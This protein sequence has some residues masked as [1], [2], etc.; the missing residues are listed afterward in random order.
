MTI[1]DQNPMARATGLRGTLAFVLAA[2][3]LAFAPASYGAFVAPT[4]AAVTTD[5]DTQSAVIV[6][7][8]GVGDTLTAFYKITSITNGTLDKSDG[9]TAI[10]NNDFITLAEGTTGVK[11][12]PD[13]DLFSPATA[14][15]SFTIEADDNGSGPGLGSPIT[16]TVTVT[17]IADTPS[18]TNVTTNE[19]TQTASGLVI[20]RNANDSTEVTHFKITAITNGALFK[21]DGTT[22]IAGNDFIT[23]AEGNAG[24]KFTPTADSIATGS[25]QFQG[26][27]SGAGAGLSGGAATATIAVT[28]IADTPSVT[29]STTNEDLQTTTGLVI[30]RNANDSTEVTHFKITAITNGA[31]FRNDGTTS[32]SNNAFITFAQANA[33]LKF[34]PSS[35][36][37]A[38]GSFAVQGATSNGG[39]G[40]SALAAT[41]TI[42]VTPIAD[43]PSVTNATTNEDVQTASGLV[44]SR[45][46]NDSTEVTHFKVTAITNGSLFQ[47]DGTTA[48][49]GN[50]FVTFAQGNAG[51]KFTPAADSFAAGSFTIQASTSGVDGGLGGSTAT[52]TITVT[53]IA[54]T[55]SVTD[56]TTNED[57]QSSSGLVISRNANDSTEVTHFKITSI[58]NGSLFRND[59]TT[60]IANNAFITFAQGNAGLKFTP[61]GNLS[62]PGT[63]F[64]FDIQGATSSGGAGLSALAATATITVNPVADTPS[65]TNAATNEDVQTTSGLVIS[66]NANDSTEVTHFKVT[67]ITNGTL[68]QNDGTTSISN[69]AFITFA[70]GNVGLKFTPTPES[71]SNGSFTIQASTSGVDGGLGGS[72]AT[73][74]I[75]VTSI[76]DTPSVTN[77]TTNEDTQSSSGLVI[78]RNAADSTEVT[79]FKITNISNGSLFRNDGTT[80]IANDA[81]ITFSQGNAG[82]KFT[83]AS[84]TNTAGTF[85]IQGATSNVGAGL[86]L[87]AANATITIT[88]INDA[89]VLDNSGSLVLVSINE[90]NFT[91]AGT[92]ISSILAVGTI[93][94]D[95]PLD[96]EGIAVTALVS[97]NG[98][99]EFSLDAGTTWGSFGS[100]TADSAT[101][102]GTD[103]FIR[104]VPDPNFNGTVSSGITF[105]AWDQSL[106]ASGDTA[107]DVSPGGVATPFS[108][109]TETANIT[110][111][112]VNDAPLLNNG[113][114]LVFGGV[115]EDPNPNNGTLVSTMLASSGT[116]PN[117]ITDLLD[118]SPQEG[119]AV[120][121]VDNTNGAWQFSTN[122]GTSWAAFGAP[123]P[124]SNTA[125]T[126]LF[127]SH[128][129]RFAPSL[130]FNGTVATG[131]TFRGWDRTGAFASGDQNVNASATG[132]TNP[133]SSATD[134][135]ALT[136]TPVNDVPVVNDD[137]GIAVSEN[138]FVDID[139]LAN[140]SDVDNV[141]G[142]STFQ[143]TIG[144]AHGS[145]GLDTNT[146]LYRY[147]PEPNYNGPDTFTYQLTDVGSPALSDS[148]L[149]SITVSA[150][151]DPPVAGNDT[152]ETNVDIPVEID[153]LANDE[154][155]ETALDP[156][157]VIVTV[158][159]SNG[160]TSV[161]PTDGVITYTPDSGFQGVDSFEYEVADTDPSS[162]ES[163]TANVTVA[164]SPSAIEVDSKIDE[165]D[166]NVSIPG[167]ISLREAVRFIADGG[168]ITFDAAVFAGSNEITL[169][170]GALEVDGSVTI[171]GPGASRL[172]INGNGLSRVFDIVAGEV[173]MTGLTVKNGSV[174]DE[175]GAGLRVGSSASLE[176]SNIVVSGN[177]ATDTDAAENER[178]GGI[179]A[180]G[181]LTIRDSNIVD[182]A[183]GA[184]GGI[185]SEGG[186][187]LANAT[188]SGNAATDRDG[189]G[190]LFAGASPV[191]A[192]AI[193]HATITGNSAE[194]GG[195]V[196]RESGILL[197]RNSIIAG[198]SATASPDVKGVVESNGTNLVE[199]ATGSEAGWEL[200]DLLGISA[201]IVLDTI[202]RDNGG[203]VFTH[204]LLPDSP[205]I[206][207]GT[208]AAVTAASLTTDQR[209]TGFPRIKGT[210]VDLGAYETGALT[211][212][213]LVDES[214]NPGTGTSLREALS[215]AEPGDTITVVPTGVMNLA[216][217][218]LEVDNSVAI[219]AAG[220]AQF[221]IDGGGAS[222]IL[223][224]PDQ[225]SH[226]AI[227][228]VTF[229][230][231]FEDTTGG[232]ALLN[233]GAM[234]M[235]DC[236][237][238]DNT[239]DGTD[240]GAVNN[241][242]L[243]VFNH[244]AF[245]GNVAGNLGG[246]IIN[247]GGTLTL[248][249]CTVTNN[250]AGFTGGG[251]HNFLAGTVSVFS[252]TV[253]DNESE[254]AAGLFNSTTGTMSLLNCSVLRNSAGLDGGGILNRGALTVANSTLSTNSATRNGGGIFQS[255]GSTKLLGATMTQNIADDA[256]SGL[257][258]GGGFKNSGGT[259]T[260]GNSIIAGNFD[261]VNNAAGGNV[262]P[263]V[264]GTFVT[265]GTNL[266]GNRNGS[267]GFTVAA[268]GDIVGTA[269]GPIVPALGPLDNY[270]GL[271]ETHVPEPQSPAI[272][273]GNDA[274]LVTP[275]LDNPPYDQRGAGF[276][277]LVDGDGNGD[278]DTV[279]M[280]ALEFLTTAPVFTSAPGLVVNED[281]VY[282]YNIVVDDVDDL[283]SAEIF[284]IS[285]IDLPDWLSFD[286]GGDGTAIL[287]GTPTN[288]DVNPGDE[289]NPPSFN[290]GTLEVSLVVEDWAH[291]T[292]TQTFSVTVTGV[293]DPPDTTDD[294]ENT[295]EDTEVPV[296]VL[297][298]DADEDGSEVF[299]LNNNNVLVHV[300]GPLVKASVAVT[301]PPLHGTTRVESE[302]GVIYY[303]PE[304]DFE[305]PSDTFVYSVSDNGVP[306]P[307]E[308]SFATVVVDV[309][310]VNDA[311]RLADDTYA[312]DED[313]PLENIDVLANDDD[314][315]ID[316]DVDPALLLIIVAPQHGTAVLETIEVD[317]LPVKTG[318]ITYTP[319]ADYNGPDSF[320]YRAF[321]NGAPLPPASATAM[322]NLTIVS[323]NDEP[324]LLADEATTLEDTLV[325]VPVLANDV[326]VDGSLVPASLFVS[327][328]PAHG[329]AVVV[330]GTINYTPNADYN[331]PD[332]LS[333]TVSDNGAPLPALSSTAILQISVTAVN[334][335]PR[336]TDDTETTIEDTPVALAVLLNDDDVDV[337]GILNTGTL[338]VEFDLASLTVVTPPAHGSTSVD[339]D[340]GIVTYTPAA[341]FD[342][343][344]FFEYEITDHGIPAPGLTTRARADIGITAVNDTPRLFDDLAFTDEEAT[345][346]VAVL[347]HGNVDDYDVDGVIL[348]ANVTIVGGPSNGVAS[349][350]PA[351]AVITYTPNAEFNGDDL[352]EYQVVDES[353]PEL[354]P[355]ATLTIRVG[356]VNDTLVA[357]D[358]T[359]VIDEDEADAGTLTVDILANDEDIDGDA[360]PSSVTIV[361][362]ATHGA[363]AIDAQTGAITYTPG[364]NFNGV[365]TFV[366]EVADFGL[367]LPPTTS[368]ATVT[369]TV[370]AVN[371][372][373]S[374]TAPMTGLVLQDTD[375]AI[376]GVAI[377][378]VDVD[379]AATPHL[380]VGLSVSDGRLTVSLG[381]SPTVVVGDGAIGTP[382]MTLRGPLQ[383]LNAALSTLVY[384]GDLLHYQFDTVVLG[385]DDLGNT[386]SGG[387][388]TAAAAV[389]VTILPTR[390]EVSTL[391]DEDDGD[392]SPGDV[393]LREAIREIQPG[394]RIVFAPGLT[395]TL[396]MVSSLGQFAIGKS[397]TIDG[398]GASV[399]T[400][401]AG[402]ASR[403]FNITDNDS[404][405][406]KQVVVRGLS[407]TDGLPAAGLG[408]GAINNTERLVIDRCVVFGNQAENGGGVFTRGAL[409]VVDTSGSGNTAIDSGG[410]LLSF[411]SETSIVRR[412]TLAGNN[413]KQGGAIMNVGSLQVENST[414][415]GNSATQDGGAIYHGT[416]ASFLAVNATITDNI[417][418]ANAASSGL[419]GGIFVVTGASPANLRNSIVA[420]N[421][422]TPNN[423]GEG[424]V[425]PDV[426]GAFAGNH[427]NIVGLPDGA[428]GFSG[429]DI[430]FGE[431]GLSAI[432]ELVDPILSDNG[433]F[434]LTHEL[435]D[436]G[437]GVNAGDNEYIATPLEGPPFHDQRGVGFDRISFGTVDIGAIE[438]Q[439]L[440]NPNDT[441][442]A[443]DDPAETAE[444]TPALIA[445]LDNDTDTD[446][447]IIPSSVVIVTPAA[448]GTAV[449]NPATGAVT[450]TPDLD[451]NGVDTFVYEVSDFGLP[452]PPVTSSATVTVT[453]AA[454]N[455]A[456]V[457]ASPAGVQGLQDQ[458][459]PIEG[460]VVSDVDVA[461]S[462][463]PQIETGLTALHGTLAI[464]TDASPGVVVVAGASGESSFAI[465]GEVAEINSALATLV[466]RGDPLYYGP[467]TIEIVA[468]DLGNTGAAGP[469]TA[470]AAVSVNIVPTQLEVGLL[471]D[472]VDGDI[473]PEHLTLREAIAA[474]VPGGR[475]SFA[476]G[477]AGTLAMDSRLGEF[478]I[479]KS[480]T[481]DGP[482]ANAI[483]ISAGLDSR[484]FKVSD[485]DSSSDKDVV[486]RGLSL[487][488]GAPAPGLNGGAIINT[489]RL[490]IDKCVFFGNAAENGGGIY[491]R[492]SI[493]IVDTS[494]SG[495]SAVDSGGF[496]LSFPSGAAI[497]RRSTIAGND[498]RQGGGIMNVGNL[499]IENST[500]SGNST[501]QSG[502]G[503]FHGAAAQLLVANA[504]VTDNIADAN[505]TSSGLG[506]GVFVITGASPADLRNCIVAGNFDTP[507]NGGGGIVHP[508]VS[509]AF[510]GNH[511][512]FIG[513]PTGSAGLTGSDIFFSE[514]GITEL[515]ELIDPVLGDN[516]GLTLTHALTL[517]GPGVDAGN[518]AFVS[519][520]WLEGPP[521]VDQRGIGFDR[522]DF[523][524]VDV[525]AVEFQDGDINDTLA[526]QDDSVPTPEDIPVQ[527]AVIDNDIDTD[528]DIIRS[529]VLIVEPAA[530]GQTRINIATGAVTYTPALNFNGVDSFVYEVRDAGLP[531]PPT[532]SRATVTIFVSAVNDAPAAQDDFAFPEEDESLDINVLVNDGDVDGNLDPASVVVIASPAH[533]TAT[534]NAATGEIT[535]TPAQNFNGA[536]SFTYRVSDTGSPLPALSD[537]AVVTISVGAV[538]DTL[539]A[540]DDD[541]VTDEDESVSIDVAANDDDLDDEIVRSSVIVV[542]PAT[543][544]NT[545]VNPS[546]GVITYTPRPNFNGVDTF[547]YEIADLGIPLPPTRSR[548][549]VTVAVN[550]VNDA[551]ELTAPLFLQG[552]QDQ[553]N[554]IDGL[555]LVDRDAGESATPFIEVDIAAANGILSFD[556][557]ATPDVLVVGG[558]AGSPSVSLRG[559]PLDLGVALNTFT[560]RADP[561]HY[562]DSISI[563]VDDLGNTG[564]GGPR[565]D[566][567]SV[568]VT[569]LPVFMEVSTLADTVDG[570]LS[571]GNLTLREAIEEVSPGG[572]IAFKS[573]LTGTLSMDSRLGD[574]DIEKALTIDGPGSTVITLSAGPASRIFN[575]SDGDS[576]PNKE[577]VIR[578]LT[579]TDGAPASPQNGGAI[580]NTERLLIDR[581]IIFGN[582]A[583]NGGGIYSRGSLTLVD[584][585]GAGNT[586]IDSGGFLYSFPSETSIVRR[587]TVNGNEARHGGG[588][589][590]VGSLRIENSTL[591]G[592]RAAQDGGGLYHGAAAQL[593]AIN[594][595][596]TNNI[597]NANPASGGVGGGIFVV[598]GASAA[599]LRNCIVA[600]NF[601]TPDNAG[602]GTV[603]PDASGAFAG[604]HNNLVGQSDGSAGLGGSD[605]FFAEAGIVDIEEVIDPFLSDNGGFTLT[606]A[607]VESSP[608][609]NAG[610]SAFIAAPLSGPPFFDQR[611]AGFDRIDFSAVDVGALEA[612]D[613]VSNEVLTAHDD[614]A[615]TNE[616][617]AVT[618]DVLD[619]DTGADAGI[620][621]AS[622]TVVIA[623]AHGATS[624][625]AASGSVTYT[626]APDFSGV[627]TFVYEV[628]DNGAPLPASSA[629]ATVTITVNAV[630]DTLAAN[631]D[632]AT[633]NEDDPVAI[634]VLANDTD[635]ADPDGG[636]D[637]SSVTIVTAASKGS[638]GV[639]PATGVVTY[640][641]APNSS[642][643]DSFVYEVRDLGAPLPATLAAAAV[644]VTVNAVNDPPVII[645]PAEVQG[646]WDTTIPIPGVTLADLDAGDA[647][648]PRLDLTVAVSNGAVTLGA[649]SGAT[650]TIQGTVA[651]LNAALST[652]AYRGAPLYFGPDTLSIEANDR[653]NT[654]SGGPAIGVAT[655][656]LMVVPTVIVVGLLEDTMDGDVSPGNITL[657]EAIA[658]SKP[659]GRIVFA[660][661]LAGTLSMNPLFGEFVVDKPLT[662]DGGSNSGAIT[663]SAGSASRVFNVSDGNVTPDKT[664][665]IRGLTLRGG[666]AGLG[667]NG[668][669]ILNTEN[670]LIDDCVISGNS[671]ENG[672]G[673]YS[674]GR[675]VVVD[676]AASANSAVDSGGFLLSFQ[677]LD[678]VIRRSTIS[679]N[680]AARGGGIMNAGNLLIENSTLSGNRADRDG[681]G[682]YH[683]AAT[684]LLVINAT[685]TGNIANGD[686]A[687]NGL[688]GG[689][690]V[691][692]S[693]ADLRNC[694]VAG[695]FDTLNN[696]GG[697][698]QHPD[699]SGSF[700]GNHK[701]LI[702]LADG[703]AGLG[704]SDL[705]FSEAGIDDI[706]EAI[707]PVLSDNGG[708]TLTH[709]LVD[710]GPA[711][712]LGDNAFVAAPLEGPPFHDQRGIG[713]ERI[714][715]GTVDAGAFET[716]NIGEILGVIITPAA[717]QRQSTAF[718][719]IFFIIEFT[720]PVI[721]FDA[722]DI[723]NLG[724][725]TGLL[726]TVTPDPDIPYRYLL[727]VNFASK[728]AKAIGAG[729]T[730]EPAI[731]PGAVTDSFDRTNVASTAP[732]GG[733]DFDTSLDSD[734]DGF[735]DIEESI[736]DA[737]VDGTPNYLDLDSD[738]DGDS[739]AIERLAETNPFET[740]TPSGTLIVAPAAI[741]ATL[742]G[743]TA[744]IT[745]SSPFETPL[746]WAAEVVDG[747]DWIE[748]GDG[749][750]G[751]T[752]GVVEISYAANADAGPRAGLVRITA[753]DAVGSPFDVTVSQV[754]CLPATPGNV[755]ATDV[756]RLIRVELTWSAAARATSYQIYR[757]EAPDFAT[758]ELLDTTTGLSYTAR[759]GNSGIFECVAVDANN[760]YYWVVAIND[761][762]QSAPILAVADFQPSGKYEPVFPAKA[763][764]D[765][766]QLAAADSP[767]AI[768]LRATQPIDPESVWG[769]VQ[770]D[771]FESNEVRWMPLDSDGMD[772][773]VIYDPVEPWEPGSTATMIAGALTL[774][775]D[776]VGPHSFSFVIES[777]Q[778][779]ELR[780]KDSA[781][782]V[783]QPRPDASDTGVSV[784]RIG[785]ESAFRIGPDA[786]FEAPV[787][788]WLPLPD[789]V[790]A[791]SVGLEYYVEDESGSAW[792]PADRIAGWLVPGSI[793]TLTR[794]GVVYIGI[795]V[796][797][798][799]TA[800]VLPTSAP[801][802]SAAILP[803]SA[804]S[805]LGDVAAFAVALSLFVAVGR[806]GS[807]RLKKRM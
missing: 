803:L 269:S 467:D 458:D 527:I 591:S 561:L 18:V 155:L 278:G 737:D 621:P 83:P 680:D 725:A 216:L 551:P 163:A 85:D 308:T 198:N 332:T 218:P 765:W 221:A 235:T 525:G 427:H 552:V 453:V 379:E 154:D 642:G 153:V 578:G 65:I 371:D 375:L 672:G 368:Q 710:F 771:G 535:Y 717:G 438:M 378:D 548:A 88:P 515:D 638:V 281:D 807:S 322:A 440:G 145:V 630:N 726:F 129:V 340:T 781:Q 271:F 275:P 188:V 555:A 353:A 327:T 331:G 165:Q 126:V 394:G 177:E 130:N 172:A 35:D 574:F 768:R 785:T 326:D 207:A 616:D 42:T 507:N 117:P 506:G 784:T 338:D 698:I 174:E 247:W 472:V 793:E 318:L 520:P 451:F 537:T 123:G 52:A 418:D 553:D 711:I 184:G 62:S 798:A 7:T 763:L 252:S 391:V 576:V 592:N 491:S 496:L 167:S 657:R 36:S 658:E 675:L 346:E 385:V 136:V 60:S 473:S 314:I 448:H 779:A 270:G 97:T 151:N 245:D 694:I 104:F 32:I 321:D 673:I 1:T 238:L 246:A 240:G 386:G 339:P 73:A 460:I 752:E 242:G 445:I 303:T 800:R 143:V 557:A 181:A 3:L 699:V 568:P 409:T 546:S 667:Q 345:V 189:G 669:A 147:S 146:N 446:Q 554:A 46:A 357:H 310:P 39:A 417:A 569:I 754:G 490:L 148:A 412:S 267:T 105:K 777:E 468:N 16:A 349:I 511:N 447:D 94:D 560:Y 704:G 20:S 641:P 182:N 751:V 217:G 423:S 773:W 295:F 373:P 115:A 509:G 319:D 90:D 25:F 586:A 22:S 230:N 66:R 255:S 534:P 558:S 382:S 139:V 114:D 135:A 573:A 761:C 797:H 317:G 92:Q 432:E 341:D 637:P 450:Y 232:G 334:D 57:T 87:L 333:Y 366:Y 67:S 663:L 465:R 530:H 237:F 264:S 96:P 388:G 262:H 624:V 312:F 300:D 623:A 61:T 542:T 98:D 215:V 495:N 607:L 706:S 731:R 718:L 415:S 499:R 799:G 53:A 58:T 336:L 488:D 531:L 399:V 471:V 351:T 764:G 695:N 477:L 510:S 113:G 661:G 776:P 15:F 397:L 381:A 538:N 650:V 10:T 266:I 529:S 101:L 406:N 27:T 37:I 380:E 603:H 402:H 791:D 474:A 195:G 118:A 11:F 206:D 580:S 614:F 610:D 748:I 231:G 715:V 635:A 756:P 102:L 324:R 766:T 17:P 750:T 13:A 601:D 108:T 384:H 142:D 444:D 790:G 611:G 408:G 185:Y 364:L 170:L 95:D 532:S 626:P 732:E 792:Y 200:T 629:L 646:L 627:D 689:I 49:A 283:D 320:Q 426:S 425:N 132:G 459:I 501:T 739:D 469:E 701:N 361:T 454:I 387:A 441:L 600:G 676:T 276:A 405:P 483:T 526:A 279:D 795:S 82:L 722:N 456:P 138:G 604:N 702:G 653:G 455:D 584:T 543:N 164:V 466:Y 158:L 376:A 150:V 723:V 41:A 783:P 81:F 257:G 670:L 720:D 348:P 211:V 740:A 168:T 9:T 258:D 313:I 562:A 656:N 598:A 742:E 91:S 736:A 137:P 767:F 301:T 482:G 311:P 110:V 393:T 234:V 414:L 202:M 395:G 249:T 632:F 636:V 757:S 528:D 475:I 741:S 599:D 248:N 503:I 127:D 428:S 179:F 4:V 183:A 671:A 498:A 272:D 131:I 71:F 505:S 420:G 289:D 746:F 422:D 86:S 431:A 369:I 619:N 256:D 116:V 166:G 253:S 323:R 709:A 350:N 24:L 452:L 762:A 223:F 652:L 687:A 721:G 500:L 277:R 585:S 243:I 99:W 133:F 372:I 254:T 517:F 612:Q 682:L 29:G 805:A 801:V 134:T 479:A 44:I 644:T 6:I 660:A 714:A 244:S 692:S 681:G 335:E 708:P 125:A 596:I 769:T 31:L 730:I 358:D 413:A 582:E 59:G 259:A 374:L 564:A 410:F 464:N 679:G 778:D 222:K 157:S 307:A 434:T 208:N 352:I 541:A 743:G 579:L 518:S 716:Q 487:T 287:T 296:Y 68:F 367:P 436:F 8:Q 111:V 597:A 72:T 396:A 639:D 251:I 365:D 328:P 14:T 401:S 480:L 691:N 782:T 493:T 40:L 594:A 683:G 64:S 516:G 219:H 533:G 273:A 735:L 109:A 634:F 359:L 788:V 389:L 404:I 306:M 693:S 330:S 21:N 191:T 539:H 227:T 47:N 688:G 370:N 590:N 201:A 342:Q 48:I 563:S 403:I 288:E 63:L 315:D 265:L 286:D 666:N 703:S 697:G 224:V 794:G 647:V 643:V 70:E 233:Y 424:I 176:L 325:A 674:S 23:F 162:P 745:L 186:I 149:V 787:T 470:N 390:L 122:G 668:G 383:E 284:A 193:T 429:S 494:G 316:G 633:T 734:A 589:M 696:A 220:S 28:P 141:I 749:H 159:P 360:L 285:A 602:G 120:I 204:A 514:V 753:P 690:F 5:E 356:A 522:V 156:A 190:I 160:G 79:H 411:P 152:A 169:T 719:P 119:I 175:D 686:P 203:P 171:T 55:P 362:P 197:F 74:T 121:A 305:G 649:A 625:D 33:G 449:L 654:G 489:E 457:L 50:D 727:E 260:A 263:D 583:E 655:V 461:E 524:T 512:N 648:D 613:G 280:G 89:P 30:S 443:Q 173:V 545:S 640:T 43:T 437:P 293:N 344:D 707:D 570:N 747:G 567:A 329:T 502:G 504:T 261:T 34:T 304:A 802:S 192:T 519:A 124:V 744:A 804:S 565:S 462:D 662:I 282:T 291:A 107:I 665:V 298:N 738:G 354:H 486:I 713:F 705:F 75:T 77:A 664:V 140:D 733:V 513:L 659:G 299:A 2:A 421:F 617:E 430:F 581:C 236:A 759:R 194:G 442:A 770:A 112:A 806:S 199:N 355:T 605:V 645:A 76:A 631:G 69:S 684:Q 758:A 80:A 571:P 700:A 492:G 214:A 212:D 228:G 241:H 398:P 678:T 615:A 536:D 268:Y 343:A 128:L 476:P 618:V 481:I 622:V 161:N 292:N 416:T 549:T 209:G 559:T 433:G 100:V 294:L 347:E 572:R 712:N 12:T 775:G 566:S 103:E 774:G 225:L 577:V 205:A 106:H 210:T 755:V 84:N 187:D 620:L 556:L 550:A 229:T 789:G 180:A 419:G 540:A 337:P 497:V 302:T 575:I 593:L 463:T 178:G 439:V 609:V 363:T 144:P 628:T 772:G 250:S 588:I 56:A 478:T 508:D 93:T 392:E 78:S 26:A 297:L 595:T 54:D 435:V 521:F 544:G 407:L 608:A 728:A 685:I 19:D 226:V 523:A 729:G 213:T 45:N 651:Q 547:V 400:I 786:V 780:G 796:R 51:L 274:L 484:I 239:A 677:S 760:Y 196:S 309:D 377:A 587:S 290:S 606:H 724:T 485:G 38:A